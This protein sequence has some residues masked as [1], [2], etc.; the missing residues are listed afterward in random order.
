MR[1]RKA[2]AQHPRKIILKIRA[3]IDQP[4]T[5]EPLVAIFGLVLHISERQLVLLPK[6][7]THLQ[8]LIA[9]DVLAFLDSDGDENK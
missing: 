1:K 6:L 9:D 4:G 2:V 8:A 5:N 7:M 3:A